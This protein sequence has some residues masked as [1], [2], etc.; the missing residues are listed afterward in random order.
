MATIYT[1]VHEYNKDTQTVVASFASTATKSQNPDSHQKLNFD[2][3]NLVEEGASLQDLKDV[4]S[5]AGLNWCESYCKKEMLDDKPEKQAEVETLVGTIWS[6]DLE[7]SETPDIDNSL[8]LDK[9]KVDL[10]LT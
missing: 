4:L 9:L 8:D 7:N 10:G 1:K 3:A 6:K 5:Q 2:I